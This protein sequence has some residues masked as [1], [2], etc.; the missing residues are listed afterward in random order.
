M[1]KSFLLN[2]G[3][4]AVFDF[5]WWGY[6]AKGIFRSNMSHLVRMKGDDLDIFF[7]S[8][9]FVYLLMAL[10]LTVFVTDA[11]QVNSAT[12]AV[13]YGTLLGFGLFVTFDFTN[14]AL[15]RDYPVKFA[16]VDVSWG[17]FMCGA[18]SLINFLILR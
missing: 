7:P 8:A 4:F 13:L 14:H 3:L 12:N 2:I 15:I 10:L 1:L 9:I 16:L 17:T 18:V 11:S 5:V 6:L